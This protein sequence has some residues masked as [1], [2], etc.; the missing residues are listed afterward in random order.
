M[1]IKYLHP[2]SPLA[3]AAI[4]FLLYLN[5]APGLWADQHS[6]PNID[7]A[8]VTATTQPNQIVIRGSGFGSITPAVTLDGVPLVLISYTDTVV[9]ALLPDDA[10]AHPGTYRL[11][12][13]NNIAHGNSSQ[14]TG[15]MD[16][17]IGAVG[18]AGPPGPAG[19]AGPRG[20]S[21]QPGTT[22]PAGAQGVPGGPGPQGPA[23]LNWKGIWDKTTIYAMN[24]A[25]QFNGSSYVASVKAPQGL[26][27][28]KN[29]TTWNLLAQQGAPGA[30]GLQGPAGPAG[31]AGKQGP[32]GLTGQAGPVG[33]IGPAGAQGPRGPA[34]PFSGYEMMSCY[35]TIPPAGYLFYSECLCTAGKQ[36]LGGG[37]EQYHNYGIP[38]AIVAGTY[39]AIHWS[40]SVNAYAPV[41]WAVTVR[42]PDPV[43][44]NQVR[45]FAMCATV[46]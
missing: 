33:P 38:D 41:G 32:Q 34:G 40:Y 21:G 43:N 46:Q 37:V 42:N 45:V 5:A 29:P 27:P 11:A 24:D 31:Q 28:D 17:T 20:T 16:V 23:G 44:A 6:T 1:S 19:A 18:P 7:T 12:V 25:V 15:T 26:Q 14:Q 8:L 22:G 13:T 9:I 4:G 2:S 35:P 3:S 10:A 36:P 39:P 30:A